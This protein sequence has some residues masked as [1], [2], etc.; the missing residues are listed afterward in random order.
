[1]KSLKLFLAASSLLVASSLA[2]VQAANPQ[3]KQSGQSGAMFTITNDP[4]VN[5]VLMYRRGGLGAL[6]FLGSFD[7]GG[8]G[9]GTGLGNQGALVMSSDNEYLYVVN[10]GSNSVSSFKVYDTGIELVDEEPIDGVTPVSLTVK[11]DLLYVVSAGSDSITGLSIDDDGDLTPLAGS[12]QSLSTTG[13]GPAQI[14]FSPD[15]TALVVTEKATNLILVFPVSEAG[16]AEPAIVNP[17]AGITPF[18]FDFDLRGYLIVSDAVGGAEGA[19]TVSSYDL[20]ADGTL[21]PVS[22]AVETTQ[23]AACWVVVAPNGLTAF[24]TNTLSESITALN[25]N[26]SGELLLK[27]EDGL[28]AATIPGSMPLDA[29]MSA[30]GIFLYAIS[31][32]DGSISA[33]R[34]TR[35][36]QL[37]PMEGVTGIVTT[38]TGLVGY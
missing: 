4:E 20:L 11:D 38:V 33:Y 2:P 35:N 1:M 10:P 13:T 31:A 36:G 19:S 7:T 17:S 34:A 3:F 9:T 24:V 8:T 18:G 16:L 28:S 29:A 15:G 23:S 12:T 6:S 21:V 27:E 22:P 37:I 14:Q 26:R 32:F 30:N 25:I 5:E